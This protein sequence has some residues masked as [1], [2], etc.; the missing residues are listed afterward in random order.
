MSEVNENVQNET[1][2]TVNAEATTPIE[3][4]EP[5]KVKKVLKWVIGGVV[6]LVTTGVGI[7]LGRNMGND[8]DD[9]SAESEAPAE[10]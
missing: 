5:G 4:K 2:E 1:Q 9:D 8:D 6:I 10:E 7:L 3:I